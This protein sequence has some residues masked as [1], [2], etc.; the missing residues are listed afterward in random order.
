[1]FNGK[2]YIIIF[3]QLIKSHKKLKLLTL[4]EQ[5]ELEIEERK[6]A[7]IDN[8]KKQEAARVAAL[9]DE[10]KAQEEKVRKE[11]EA[12]ERKRQ[13]AKRAEAEKERKKKEAS[14][15]K[16]K[17]RKIDLSEIE[18]QVGK[19]TT[20]RRTASKKKGN[21]KRKDQLLKLFEKSQQKLI[22]KP[23][24]RFTAKRKKQMIY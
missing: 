13:K 9:E 21:D 6:K 14:K 19:G 24:R 8:K 18:A 10:Q 3:V 22:P 4:Q 11:K 1:M 23:K 5:R 16:K 12:A 15:P 20:H 17:F 2:H 7:E